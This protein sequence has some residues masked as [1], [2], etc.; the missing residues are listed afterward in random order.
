VTH[1]G[2]GGLAL[3][4]ERG[5]P[6][7]HGIVVAS[8]IVARHG[9]PVVCLSPQRGSEDLVAGSARSVDRLSLIEVLRTID[10]RHPGL[11][12]KYGGHAMRRG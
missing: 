3:W 6:G 4:L 7:A 1:H 10:R 9:H 12:V 2:S 5:H 8:R 11:F